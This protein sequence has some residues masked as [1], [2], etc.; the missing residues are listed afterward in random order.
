MRILVLDLSCQIVA[1]SCTFLV[2][3]LLVPDRKRTTFRDRLMMA[4]I[5]FSVP[6]YLWLVWL[7]GNSVY[8]AYDTVEG[9]WLHVSWYERH[10]LL[11][12]ILKMLAHIP[13]LVVTEPRSAPLMVIHHLLSLTCYGYA[14]YDQRML[15]WGAL[16]GLCEITTI[17]MNNL[18]L[19]RELGLKDKYPIVT[20][21]NGFLF[22]LTYIIFRLILFPV[23]LGGVYYDITY[24]SSIVNWESFSPIQRFLYP[25]TNLVLFVLSCSWFWKINK[26]LNKLLKG[27]EVI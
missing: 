21:I 20:L 11:S 4:D 22:W 19:L 13:I 3:W 6:Y 23:W 12:Y 1:L 27:P 8:E 5:F 24:H 2:S 16:D 25:F 26:G 14:L 10:F 15:W 18:Y 17:F 9:R 7:C